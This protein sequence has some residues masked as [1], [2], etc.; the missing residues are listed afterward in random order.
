MLDI[1]IGRQPIYDRQLKVVAYELLYRDGSQNRAQFVDGDAASRQ[2]VIN[3]FLE[4]GLDQLVEKHQKAFINLTRNF[5]L[6]TNPMPFPKEQVVLE[7]LE[8]IVFDEEMLTALQRLVQEGYTLALDD[9]IFS[10]QARAACEIAKIVKIDVLALDTK[11]LEEHVRLL[12]TF[13]VKLLA[14][15]VETHAMLMQCKE[16]GFD[17]FQGYF[18]SRPNIVAGKSPPSMRITTLRTLGVLQNPRLDLEELAEVIAQ[19]VSLSYKLLR[20]INS[21]AVAMPRK[22]DSVR[23]ALVIA[24]LNCIRSWATLIALSSIDDKPQEL[25]S[26]AL[27][28]GKMCELIAEKTRE[29][30]KETFFIGNY[31]PPIKLTSPARAI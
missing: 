8:D 7:V 13:N 20:Y 21:A 15:K 14:E 28:R 3:T 1:Y 27:I 31:S 2:V 24:G 22:I 11:G 9:F 18:L 19:D 10:E 25:M 23:Q 29:K 30:D 6:H 17:Y 16:L 26:I 5:F 12:R 4:I